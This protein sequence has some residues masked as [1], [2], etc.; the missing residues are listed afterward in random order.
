[1]KLENHKAI[2]TY[3]SHGKRVCIEYPHSDLDINEFM[4][5][6]RGVAIASGYHPHTVSEFFQDEEEE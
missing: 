6:V 4:E 3:E 2:L 1:M 5:M